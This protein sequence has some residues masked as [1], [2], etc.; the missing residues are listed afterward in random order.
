M[1]ETIFCEESYFPPDEARTVDRWSYSG[2]GMA[3][4]TRSGL[5]L[6]LTELTGH[7][8]RK[9]FFENSPLVWNLG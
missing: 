8:S 1:H 7:D 9:I 4:L 5:F 6:T 3:L 2:E